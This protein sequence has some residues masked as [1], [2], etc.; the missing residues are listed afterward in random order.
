MHRSR[1]Q[2]DLFDSLIALHLFCVSTGN[3]DILANKS[4]CWDLLQHYKEERYKVQDKRFLVMHRSG[5][6]GSGRCF[7]KTVKDLFHK[8]QSLWYIIGG[9]IPWWMGVKVLLSVIFVCM[10]YENIQLIFCDMYNC[11]PKPI[12]TYHMRQDYMCLAKEIWMVIILCS[13]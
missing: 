5:V 12:V 10:E 8:H 4:K 9:G 6:T 7:H 3:K 13:I 1:L 11:K 2:L